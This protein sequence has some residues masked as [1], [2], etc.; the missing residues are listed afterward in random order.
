MPVAQRFGDRQH[1]GEGALDRQIAAVPAAPAAVDAA[2]AGREVIGWRAGLLVKQL[3]LL[4]DFG[5][6]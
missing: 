2:T 5:F 1:L 6:Q 4:P 3:L